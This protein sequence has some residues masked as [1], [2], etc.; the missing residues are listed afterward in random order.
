[1]LIKRNPVFL[2]SLMFVLAAHGALLYF[3]FRQQLLPPPE[4]LA[5]LFVNFVPAMKPKEESKP[6]PPP[7]APKPQPVKKPQAR[8]LVAE[9]PVL[10][11]T[12]PVAAPPEPEPEPEPIVMAE[13]PPA[14]QPQ[15]PAGPVTLS[16]ELSVACPQLNAPTYPSLSRRLGEEGKLVLRVELDENGQVNVAQVV[17]SSGYKRLDEA[18]IAAVKTWHCNPPTRGGQP[19]RAIALQP[20]NF[21][22]QGD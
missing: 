6:E 15:M 20:F 2:P 13:T 12:E 14:P 11:V 22:L 1:M 21:V 4:Q 5:T 16:S 18:A 7:P 19:V 10:S 17:N 9:T 3:L 8:Q